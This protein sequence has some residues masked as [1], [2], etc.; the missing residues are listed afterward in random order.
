MES[1]GPRLTAA[2]DGDVVVVAEP[3]DD[4]FSPTRTILGGGAEVVVSLASLSRAALSGCELTRCKGN[5]LVL[6]GTV[7]TADCM[8]GVV[9]VDLMMTVMGELVV[10]TAV[11]WGEAVGG[12]AFTGE[13]RTRRTLPSADTET[14][15]TGTILAPE[16][17]M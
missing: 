3:D 5:V 12:V 1:D 8:A 4:C 9:V 16:G 10:V 14:N 13:T 17:T 7:V 11:T 2:V 6:T 15:L